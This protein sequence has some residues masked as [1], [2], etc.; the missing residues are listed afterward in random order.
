LDHLPSVE[1]K[2]AVEGVVTAREKVDDELERGGFA[3]WVAEVE[4]APGLL[5]E[6]VEM[7]EGS[8]ARVGLMCFRHQRAQTTLMELSRPRN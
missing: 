7:D 6:D 4:D 1:E 5:V 2:P 3:C 8:R